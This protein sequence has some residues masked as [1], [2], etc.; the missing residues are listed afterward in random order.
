M[1]KINQQSG[2]LGLVMRLKDQ[3]RW[4]LMRVKIPESVH[5]HSMDT[6]MITHILWM[7]HSKVFKQTDWDL[8]VLLEAAMV[9]DLEESVC[10]DTSFVCKNMTLRMS[11]ACAEIAEIAK[12][13]IIN[14]LPYEMREHMTQA[15]YPVEEVHKVVKAADLLSALLKAID[16]VEAFNEKEFGD[17]LARQTEVIKDL[18]KKMPEVAYFME[19]FTPGMSMSYDKLANEFVQGDEPL[20]LAN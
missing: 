10:Q 7:I 1:T 20:K 2:F 4:P 8:G 6:V 5:S 3:F 18:A 13:K 14:T 9:H 19:V 15:M 17:V 11:E 12:R 16:E